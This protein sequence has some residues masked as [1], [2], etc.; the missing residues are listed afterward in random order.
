MGVVTAG[1]LLVGGTLVAVVGLWDDLRPLPVWIRLTAYSLAVAVALLILWDAGLSALHGAMP[2]PAWAAAGVLFVCLLWL[3]NLYN[4][5]DGI[6]GLAAVQCLVFCAGALVI[7]DSTSELGRG[8]VLLAGA[9]A[10]FLL[11]NRAPAHIFMGDVGSTFLG[12]AIGVLALAL[13]LEWQ[14]PLSASLILLAPFVVDASYT[15]LVRLLT[16]QPISVAHCDHAYQKAARRHGHGVV[17]N[18]LTAYGILWLIPLAWT[19][20]ARPQWSWISLGASGI[21]LLI[22]CLYYNAG[23]PDAQPE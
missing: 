5:M 21:P 16:A 20:A 14:M 6:D 19:A 23:L 8:V 15:L 4:F 12:L 10:A 18:T 1:A 9:V 22:L 3:V 13:A 7:G 17:T 11:H 2:L